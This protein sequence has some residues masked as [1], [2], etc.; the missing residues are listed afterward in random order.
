MWRYII[1]LWNRKLATR[2]HHLIAGIGLF[3]CCSY[4]LLFEWSTLPFSHFV[5]FVAY[6][7][8][9]LIWLLTSLTFGLYRKRLTHERYSLCHFIFHSTIGVC[10]LFC[11]ACCNLN[12]IFT[13]IN[14]QIYLKFYFCHKYFHV[15]P[16]VDI[17]ANLQQNN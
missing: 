10:P 17:S 12:L 1:S 6:S 13:C 2:W 15:L 11:S 3:Q 4:Q 9:H 16:D 5:V 8:L 14:R 7:K